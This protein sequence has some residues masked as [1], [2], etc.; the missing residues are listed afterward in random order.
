M[1]KAFI[2]GLAGLAFA[3]AAA[4][5]AEQA[6]PRTARRHER[7][8]LS[9]EDTKAYIDAHVAA[10]KASLELTQEQER[11]WPRLEQALR[12]I[13]QSRLDRLEAWREREAPE[14]QVEA[15][16][17][18]A[19]ALTERAGDLRKLASAIEPLYRTL[20]DQQKRRLFRL[21]QMAPVR[22][23]RGRRRHWR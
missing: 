2:A 14:D 6:W 20:S 10:V 3:I 1:R 18:Q 23:H 22:L 5:D 17:D 16:R 15:M 4:G 21:M 19:D 9:S 7:Q 13:T 8:Q 11:H 12:D